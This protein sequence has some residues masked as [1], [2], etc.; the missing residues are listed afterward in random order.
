MHQIVSEIE[1][2]RL[3]DRQ[4]QQQQILVPTTTVLAIDIFWARTQSVVRTRGGMAIHLPAATSTPLLPCFRLPF[5]RASIKSCPQPTAVV[6]APMPSPSQLF[7][8]QHDD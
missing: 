1:T 2:N 7:L 3:T 6:L 5:S 4:M 8:P